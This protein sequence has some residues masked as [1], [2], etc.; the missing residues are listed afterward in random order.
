MS[1]IPGN[2]D[3]D[4]AW[5]YWLGDG[6]QQFRRHKVTGRVEVRAGKG[7]HQSPVR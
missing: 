7:L 5:E 2:S 4:Q 3:E 1:E 6:A